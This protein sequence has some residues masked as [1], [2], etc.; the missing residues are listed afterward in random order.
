VRGVEA[1]EEPLATSHCDGMHPEV[2]LVDEVLFDQRA[3]EL[4]CAELQD[5]LAGLIL[6]PGDLFTDIALEECRVPLEWL[7]K[8]L[9]S[10]EL[11][12]AVDPLS[13]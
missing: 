2:E 3:V 5:A 13:Q 8:G 9:R 4:P 1:V 6:Q 11:G 10:D 7:A 12:E